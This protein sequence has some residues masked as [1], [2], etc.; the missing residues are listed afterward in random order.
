MAAIE[1]AAAAAPAS[2]PVIIEFTVKGTGWQRGSLYLNSEADY[3]DQR[4]V[5]IALLPGALEAL[6]LRLGEDLKTALEG[7]RLVVA[8]RA[9]RVTVWFFENDRRTDKYYYQTHVRV[10]NAEQVVSVR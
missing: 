1:M 8:G 9:E 2:V 10:S 6:R 4:S 5:T 7:R 3:R